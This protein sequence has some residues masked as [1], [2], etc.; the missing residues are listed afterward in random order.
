MKSVISILAMLFVV[1]TSF[2]KTSDNRNLNIVF[3]GNSIT[4]GAGLENPTREAPPV[5]AAIY[6]TRQPFIGSVKYSNQGVSGSTTVDF[7]PETNTLFPKVKAAA[8]KFKDEDWATLVFSI[9]L[10]TNDSAI[11][12]TNGCPVSPKQYQKNMRTIID[13]LI[14]LYPGCKIV[15]HRPLWYSPNTHNASEYLQEGLDRLQTYYPE[16]K[17]LVKHYNSVKKGCVYLGDTDGFDYFRK[18]HKDAFQAE[19]GN[20]GV[21]YLHPNKEG[22]FYLGKLWGKAIYRITETR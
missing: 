9:M 1:A 20:S 7:L 4:Y 5:K 14:E 8:D 16:I 2:G 21:F 12:G 13:K 15:V 11:R 22:A 6:L 19:N 3:V 18:N 10:G 17:K